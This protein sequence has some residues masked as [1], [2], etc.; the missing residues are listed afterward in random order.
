MPQSMRDASAHESVN[1][2]SRQLM[3]MMSRSSAP[4]IAAT[5][6]G[7]SVGVPSGDSVRFAERETQQTRQYP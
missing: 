7:T 6:S 4:M 3:G 5:D 2:R 1:R